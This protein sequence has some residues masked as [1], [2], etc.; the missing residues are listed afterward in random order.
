MSH[1]YA[2]FE[3]TPLWSVL[4]A[5]LAELETNHDVLLTTTRAHVVGLLC[6]RLTSGGFATASGTD[7]APDAAHLADFLEQAALAWPSEAAWQA[8]LR[9]RYADAEAEEA[10]RQA[11]LTHLRYTQGSLTAVQAAEYL[12][13]IARGL[14]TRGG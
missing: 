2:E 1:P 5:T 8:E 6:E 10:R 9:V 13:T 4:A 14:R 3:G 7:A 12:Q 11:L